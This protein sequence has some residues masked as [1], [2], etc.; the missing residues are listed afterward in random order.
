MKN[1]VPGFDRGLLG[2]DH[3][4]NVHPL[5]FATTTTNQLIETFKDTTGAPGI[6]VCVS[7][8]GTTVYS[9]GFGFA[10]VEQ[11]VKVTPQTKFRIASI[12]KS[13]T[14]LLAG[15]MI[16]QGRLNLDSDIATYLPGFSLK[17]KD[18]K[19]APITMRQLL[20]HTS[21]IRHYLKSKEDEDEYT[22]EMLNTKAYDSA[23]DSLAIF[24]NDALSHLPGE[25]Y[26][27]ST[28]G[29]TVAAAVL[30]AIM[31]KKQPL[32][33]LF[34]QPVRLRAPAVGDTKELPK[35]AKSASLFKQLFA[36]LNLQETC[37]DEPYL[38][39]PFR[40]RPYRRVKK[41]KRLENTPW[42]NN[43]CKWAGGGL[44]STAPD[45]VRMA[46]HLADIYMGRFH[47]MAELAVVSRNTLVNC[48]WRPNRGTIQG[49]WLPGGL[50]G[51]GWF[52][53][54][55]STTPVDKISPSTHPD[56]LYV[57]H[58]GG[59][60]GFTSILFMSLPSVVTSNRDDTDAPLSVSNLPP[61]CVVILVNLEE[62][63]GIG[64]LAIHIAEVFTAALLADE[65]PIS[66]ALPAVAA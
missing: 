20:N 64:E 44:L 6:S 8:D 24:R 59:A 34:E 40:A 41:T 17:T 5:R 16:D 48:L 38:I 27:Y 49:H 60:I 31:N 30:E 28:H 19:S 39:I 11:G 23:L 3:N 51:L 29:F 1:E 52:I 57:G 15:R 45:L 12:S 46:N 61:I 21:G 7:V 63:R 13:F 32:C 62:A 33:P 9:R 37:L 14:S 53:A 55:R 42:V 18:G 36:F 35:E 65:A 10:D 26:L 47:N 25:D 54:R 58:T 22:E 2:N 56:R 50:Y 43:S 66:V 4:E